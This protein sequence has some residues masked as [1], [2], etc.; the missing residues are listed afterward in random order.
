MIKWVFDN[1][2]FSGVCAF[3]SGSPRGVSLSLADGA[4]LTGGGDGVTVVMTGKAMLPKSQRTFDRYFD[5][6]VFRRPARGERGSG[7]GASR[8]A[9]RGPGINNWDL[10]F[11]KNVPVKERLSLQF[12]WE[13]YNAFNHTQFSGVDATARFDAQ[14]RQINT[15]FGQITSSRSPRI[16]QFA[17]RLSF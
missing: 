3:V 11:F 7:A 14:G 16:Q 4:D 9:F 13:M 17:L 1:W 8:Y 12:R 6:S 10:T 2:Q 5:T 15:G